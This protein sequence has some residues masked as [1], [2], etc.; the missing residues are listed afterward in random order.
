LT[1]KGRLAI[2]VLLGLVPSAP[3]EGPAPWGLPFPTFGGKQLWSD[4]WI[5]DGWR[6]QQ[7]CWTGRFRL[8]D[9]RDW[10]RAGG[11]FEGC[12]AA[13]EAYQRRYDLRPRGPHLVVLLP[14]LIRSK[15]AM[16]GLE[17]A[18]HAAGFAT[19]AVDYPT[20]QRS[21]DEHA[22][23]LERL[24]DRAQG[25]ERVSF[26]THSMG[27]LVVRVLL[28]RAAAESPWRS[29]I[30]LGR[31]CMIAP[32]NQGSEKARRWHRQ[33]WYRLALGPSGQE[34]TP[35]RVAGLPLPPCP[36]TIIAG[37]RGDGR[38]RSG[39]VPGD[40]DGTVGVA[41]T[42]LPGAVAEHLVDIDHTFGMGDPRVIRIVVEALTK[43]DSL[44]D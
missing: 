43:G 10:Q 22:D 27:G 11:D 25:I 44:K 23:Q 24:L 12:R 21:L 34:L 7:N 8:L 40:D 28:G 1:T 15:E 14:G 20:T 35:E 31:V 18:L 19:M 3:A 13:L 6:I 29:R 4:E 36:V 5:L 39:I 42:R 37:G 32:P 2:V 41:E 38:G 26:V 30:A 16:R 17:R 9:D 33:L